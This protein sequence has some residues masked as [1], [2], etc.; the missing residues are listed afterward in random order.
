MLVQAS[1]RISYLLAL[2]IPL[3]ACGKKELD[4]EQLDA[5]YRAPL[6]PQSTGLNV[7][8]LGHSLVNQDMPKMVQKIAGTGHDYRSQLGWG[9]SLKQ[10]WEPM[11]PI[12]GFKSENNHAHFQAVEA[13]IASANYDAFVLT[14][15]VEIKDAIEHHQSAKYLAKYVDAIRATHSGVP[16]YLYETW[17]N[18]DDKEGWL[19]RLERDLGLYWESAIIDKA[20][21]LS[22]DQKPIYVIPVGQVMLALF[23]DIRNNGPIGKITEPKDLFKVKADGSQ[24]TIH[25]NATGNFISALTHYSVLYRLNPEALDCN[26][27]YIIGSSENHLDEQA[28]K[29]VQAIVWR[30]VSQNSRTGFGL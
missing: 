29:R 7:Y 14:E 6:H 15:M 23:N 9:V 25:L 11:I 16:I 3:M 19:I 28:C 1:R 17:H 20:I 5:L 24:D 4:A 2:F 18:I 21:A 26:T 27:G 12:N 30:V 22:K 13:A 10:H 8:H